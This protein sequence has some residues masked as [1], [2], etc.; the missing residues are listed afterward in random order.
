MKEFDLDM[1]RGAG[2]NLDIIPPPSFSHGDVPF[3]YMYVSRKAT[4]KCHLLT[5]LGID[6]IQQ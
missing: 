3:N 4:S 5:E 1:S 2:S 6:K